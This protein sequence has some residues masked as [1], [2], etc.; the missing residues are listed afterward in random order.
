MNDSLRSSFIEVSV[1]K[2]SSFLAK[3]ALETHCFTLRRK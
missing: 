2:N 3:D 1:G